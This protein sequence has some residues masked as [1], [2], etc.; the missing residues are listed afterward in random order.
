MNAVSA[1]GWKLRETT[2]GDIEQFMGWFPDAESVDIW[3]GP[4]FRFPFT[5]ESFLKDC[6]WDV[7]RSYSL[8]D[9]GG[10]LA[11]FGQI[12]N[13]HERGH[14]AR[15][16][17]NPV[18]RRQGAGTRL[19]RML[20]RIAGE[21]LGFAECSLFVYRHNVPA[22]QCYLALGFEVQAYPDDARMAD[23]CY[24]LTRPSIKKENNSDQ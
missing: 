12:Y 6:Q 3:G 11:A 9:P 14:L 16:I 13:R 5:R 21:Q 18:M 20:M 17:S 8:V 10:R 7:M 23:K 22:Y 1:D 4:G 24:F 2:N 19:I 15:L